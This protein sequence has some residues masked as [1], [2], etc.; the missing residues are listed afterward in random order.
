MHQIN[1]VEEY[2][3]FLQRYDS[4]NEKYFRGQEKDFGSIMPAIA[5]EDGYLDNESNIISLIPQKI[6]VH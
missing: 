3:K 5:R 2:L 1:S 4:Y 6:S